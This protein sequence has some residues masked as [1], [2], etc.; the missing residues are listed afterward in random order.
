MVSAAVPHHRWSTT[1]ARRRV[2]RS[3]GR[4][5]SGDPPRDRLRRRLRRRRLRLLRG[6]RPGV[7]VRAGQLDVPVEERLAALVPPPRRHLIRY[8]GVLAPH[9]AHRRQIVP[10]AAAARTHEPPVAGRAPGRLGWA[11]W[12]GRVFRLDLQGPTCGGALRIIAAL[13][14]PDSI[15]TYLDGVGLD[16]RP[17]PVAPACLVP[18]PSSTS[19]PEPVHPGARAPVRRGLAPR[20]PA[21]GPP[22]GPQFPRSG[23][24][25]P[26]PRPRAAA[27]LQAPAGHRRPLY[28]H[29]RQQPACPLLRRARRPFVLPTPAPVV[30]PS[31]DAD[32][33][34]EPG[35]H[36]PGPVRRV[37]RSPGAAQQGRDQSLPVADRL[38]AAAQGQ[39][40]LL[41]AAACLPRG[42]QAD[43]GEQRLALC[44]PQAR[45]QR[46]PQAAVLVA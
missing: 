26:G 43:L 11:Q 19:P 22:A 33:G 38:Q 5:I 6:G 37:G 42:V 17:P 32:G 35:S 20:G 1:K 41:V 23:T 27:A 45:L 24:H 46:V 30:Q 25:P 8:H 4:S 13:T 2:C 36:R 10:A 40:Q 7:R 44:A 34:V 14:N 15:R 28:P 31:A 18:S 3:K 16:C 9:A 21:E 12:Q 29:Q 39:R